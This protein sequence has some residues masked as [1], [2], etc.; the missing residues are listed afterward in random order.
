MKTIEFHAIEF[1]DAGHA[2]QHTEASGS[3]RAIRCGGKYLVVEESEAERIE[4][5][6]VEFALLA[7]HEMPDGTFRIMTIPVND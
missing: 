5:A 7:D 4:A 1:E 6:G 3:G 2:L